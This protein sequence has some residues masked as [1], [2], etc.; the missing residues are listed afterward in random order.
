[1]RTSMLDSQNE[2][3]LNNEAFCSAIEEGQEKSAAELG[4]DWLRTQVRESGFIRQIVPFEPLDK[5]KIQKSLVNDK[6][7][8]IEEKE[9]DSPAAATVPFRTGPI[10]FYIR[11]K[12]YPVG[13][14]VIQ[15]QRAVKDTA[16][17]W[18]YNQDVRK[19][20]SDNSVKDMSAEEDGRA[21]TAMEALLL[22]PDIV[23][24]YSGVAQWQ[25]VSGGIDR[26]TT[27]EALSIMEK[28][29]SHFSPATTLVNN[30]TI[31][32]ILKWGRDEFGGDGSQDLLIDGF[33]YE[34]FMRVK[35][36]ITIKRNLVPDMR[37]YFFG[38]TN[39]LGKAYEVEAPTMY[40]KR[41][42][43]EISFFHYEMVGMTWGHSGGLAIAD[44]E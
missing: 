1:M 19:I 23:M 35:W 10:S 9:P 12:R 15:S 22:G 4:T 2:T 29:E 31:R 18:S 32:Q 40:I 24:P 44:F 7:Y 27:Q 26:N 25:T 30:V 16:E 39:C 37:M 20:I 41:E 6:F 8:T 3:L 17:L 11:P 42:G 38:P 36:I 28:T 33:T 13:F 5:S 43:R 21:L 14:S 34:T